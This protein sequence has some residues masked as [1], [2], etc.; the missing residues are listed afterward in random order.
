ME[1]STKDNV[2]VKCLY[3][4]ANISF[5]AILLFY[6]F[7]TYP[8]VGLADIQFKEVTTDAGIHHAGTSFGASWGDFNGDGWPDLWVGNHNSKPTLYLNRQDGTFED[9]IDQVWSGNPRADTHGA[10]WADFDNDGDQ[11]LVELVDV[12]DIERT[13]LDGL[14]QSEHCG[15]FSEVAKA[16]WMRREDVDL[17]RIVDYALR[18]NVGAVI[19]RLGYLLEMFEAG[20]PHE[21]DR[22]R[23]RLTASYALLDPLLPAE[24]KYLARWRLRLNVDAEEIKS[25]VSS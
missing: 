25:L 13:I 14:K 9:T 19:R 20:A 2:R 12:S 24:G 5:Y 23:K 17:T 15:G 4:R 16:F 1:N 10:A 18:L 6:F 8:N 22:L 7:V 3:C 11:D 21:C